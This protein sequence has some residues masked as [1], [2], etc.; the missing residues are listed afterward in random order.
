[1]WIMCLNLSTE[2]A[3]N[4]YVSYIHENK[5]PINDFLGCCHNKF[6]VSKNKFMLI[7]VTLNLHS[8]TTA[9]T[10]ILHTLLHFAII[11]SSHLQIS[12]PCKL[13]TLERKT[14]LQIQLQVSH[15]PIW[16][17]QLTLGAYSPYVLIKEFRKARTT[18]SVTHG[19]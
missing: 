7:R 14:R 8:I 16:T 17:Q 11:K 15:Q 19:H 18:M 10:R 9:A 1:M 4:Q 3:S 5:Y 6:C 13:R 12:K 2:V